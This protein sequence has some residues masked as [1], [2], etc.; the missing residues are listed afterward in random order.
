MG[1]RFWGSGRLRPS[2]VVHHGLAPPSIKWW[3]AAYHDVMFVD[4]RLIALPK[5]PTRGPCG[6]RPPK[7]QPFLGLALRWPLNSTPCRLSMPQ[8]LFSASV[9][10]GYTTRCSAPRWLRHPSPIHTRL[11]GKPVRRALILAASDS[12]R[13]PPAVRADAMQ[14]GCTRTAKW[15]RA[16]QVWTQV[17]KRRGTR[18]RRD[19][20]NSQRDH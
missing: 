12:R 8:I 5:F 6:Q 1:F 10:C 19:Q 4:L 3:G 14:C 2:T 17:G 20:S 13:R 9:T 7:L 16:R 15:H 18:W 11:L